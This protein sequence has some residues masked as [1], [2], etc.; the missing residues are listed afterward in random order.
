MGLGCLT[1]LTTVPMLHAGGHCDGYRVIPQDIC[2]EHS[3]VPAAQDDCPPCDC[4]KESTTSTGSISKG[5]LQYSENMVTMVFRTMPALVKS[6]P[7]H[8]MKTSRVCSVICRQHLYCC[9]SQHTDQQ[10]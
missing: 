1:T 9:M 4:P 2:T 7:V 5:V 3:K 8:S 10:L 6:V